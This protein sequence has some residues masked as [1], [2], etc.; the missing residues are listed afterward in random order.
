MQAA[1][2]AVEILFRSE[3]YQLSCHFCHPELVSGSHVMRTDC[4]ELQEW[5]KEESHLKIDHIKLRIL[6]EFNILLSFFGV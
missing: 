3:L 1:R 2:A 6:Q 4:Y 5:L